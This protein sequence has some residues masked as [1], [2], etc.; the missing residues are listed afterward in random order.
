MLSRARVL[1]VAGEVDAALAECAAAAEAF[2]DNT[3][4][5]WIEGSV[6]L[7]AEQTA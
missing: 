1:S 6:L 4:P 7:R 5:P 2:P 3:E